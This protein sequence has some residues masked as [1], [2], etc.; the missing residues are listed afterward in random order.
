MKN[1]FVLLAFGFLISGC[2]FETI[3]TGNRG[4]ETNFGKIVGEPL[5]EGL[6]FYNPFTSD[7]IEIEVRERKVEGVADSFTRDTQNVKVGFAVVLYPD[8]SQIHVIYQKFGKNWD[9]TIVAPLIQNSIK[10]VIGQNIADDLVGK[11]DQMRATAQKELTQKLKERSVIVTSLAFTNLDFDDAYEDAV[12][13]KVVAIQNALA[14]KNRSVQIEEKAKQTVA[15]A[16]ADAESMR[17][18]TQALSQNK[19]L[20]EYELAQKWDG[21]L[22]T[23]MFGSSIPMINLGQLTS[24]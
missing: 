13:Q 3:D 23:Q 24:K 4:I 18:K 2:G 10:D 22:P 5:S 6:H 7:I 9:E 1:I 8:P 14:E 17:I 21:K 11:R 19:G 15:A 16:K 12:E 20:V